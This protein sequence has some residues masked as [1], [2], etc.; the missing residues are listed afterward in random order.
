MME[1]WWCAGV[2][3]D[4]ENEEEINVHRQQDAN[5]M[6]VRERSVRVGW[7]RKCRMRMR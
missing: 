2:R 6:D 4:D 3:M 7:V 1:W 5:G